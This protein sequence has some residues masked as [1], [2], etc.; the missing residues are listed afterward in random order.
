M[1][2]F[3]EILGLPDSAPPSEVRRVCAA[4]RIRRPHPDFHNGGGSSLT[5]LTTPADADFRSPVSDVA[6]DFVDVSALLDRIQSSFF[7]RDR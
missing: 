5:R 7:G 2:D 1:H 3:F 6:I 4:R